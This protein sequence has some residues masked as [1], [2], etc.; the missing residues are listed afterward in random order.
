MG[1]P[2]VTENEVKLK[3]NEL[4]LQVQ[5]SNGVKEMARTSINYQKS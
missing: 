3:A 5:K 4:W 1:K 2:L